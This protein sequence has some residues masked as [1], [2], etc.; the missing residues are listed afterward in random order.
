MEV[1]QLV[2]F[3]DTLSLV[4]GDSIRF[5][6][7]KVCPVSPYLYPNMFLEVVNPSKV[8]NCILACFR[9]QKGGQL[10]LV[11]ASLIRHSKNKSEILFRV[12]AP[13]QGLTIEQEVWSI[14]GRTFWRQRVINVPF[15]PVDITHVVNQQ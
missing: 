14:A 3:Y 12:I 7:L 5:R 11:V 10:S 4:R 1:C 2:A 8:V 9:D 13:S 6:C 15:V